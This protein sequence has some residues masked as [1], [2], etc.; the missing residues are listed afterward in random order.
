MLLGILSPPQT[1]MRRQ[2]PARESP[3]CRSG[4]LPWRRLLSRHCVTVGA[5]QTANPR[6]VGSPLRTAIL[7]GI[8]CVRSVR[9]SRYWCSR[10]GLFPLCSLMQRSGPFFCTQRTALAVADPMS[11]RRR[12]RAPN[13]SFEVMELTTGSSTEQAEWLRLQPLPPAPPSCWPTLPSTTSTCD[14]RPTIASNAE[15]KEREAAGAGLA[16]LGRR[17][18]ST[19]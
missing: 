2:S 6:N 9:E 11:C 12:L 18:G 14:R 7:A 16:S 13:T 10:T 4:L 17:L 1:H 3:S 19:A 5:M 8:A 15:W